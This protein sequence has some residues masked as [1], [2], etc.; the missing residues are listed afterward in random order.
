M[1]TETIKDERGRII[2]YIVEEGD[3]LRLRGPQHQTLGFYSRARD[4]TLNER[5]KVVGRGNQLLRLLR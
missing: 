4:H 3:T 5:H 1:N 2:G